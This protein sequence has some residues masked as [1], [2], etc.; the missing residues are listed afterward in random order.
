[1]LFVFIF[2]KLCRGRPLD[3]PVIL[4]QNHIGFADIIVGPRG[5]HESESKTV[6]RGVVAPPPTEGIF[7]VR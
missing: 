4:G 2:G 5:R 7:G 6:L 3:G 1:M